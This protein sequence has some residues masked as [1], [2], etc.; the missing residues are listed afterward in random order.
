MILDQTFNDIVE[1]IEAC[2]KLRNDY[3]EDSEEITE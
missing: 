2:K 3:S 1:Y